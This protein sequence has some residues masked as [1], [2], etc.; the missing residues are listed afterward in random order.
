[1]TA[2]PGR[3]TAALSDRYRLEREL[4]QGGMATVY[5]AEDLKH[6]RKVAIKVLHPELSAVIGGDRFLTEI[7]VTANLQHPHILGLIDSGAVSLTTHD[8]RLSA[9]SRLS[10]DLL[11]YVMPYVS[12]ESLRHRLSRD[13]QL[14][15]ADALRLAK[16]VASALDYAHRQGVVHRDIKPE[17][18]LLQDGSALVADFGIALAVQQAGGSRMTQTGMSLGTPAYMSPEQAMGERDIG[19]RSDVY[20]LGAMTYEMLTGEPPFTGLNS[21]AIVAKVLTEQPPLLRPRRPL[22][23]SAVE[24]A[25]LTALQKLPADR[26]GSAKD[27]AD[28]LDDKGYAATVATSATRLP[29]PPRPPRLGLIAGIALISTAAG[30]AGWLAHR[31]PDAQVSRQ[32]VVL[33]QHPRGRLLAAGI[34]QL[35]TQSAIA[36]DGSSIVYTDSISGVYHLLRKRRS[37]R[38]AER[39]P[40]TEG[41]V[42]P[43]FSPDGKWIGYVT[44]DG[45]LRKV[46]VDGGGSITIAENLNTIQMAATWLDD[47]TIVYAGGE[48]SQLYQVSAEGGTPS[49][50]AADSGQR[51]NLPLVVSP[52]P[53]SRGILLTGCPGN[54]A[55][56]SN[57]YLLDFAADS[58]RLLVPDAA[59]AWISATGHLL[60]TDRAGGLYAAG[61]DPVKMVLTTPPRSIIEDV[62]PT[63]LALSQTGTALYTLGADNPRMSELVWVS[64]GGATEPV[65]TAWRGVFDYPALSPD[66]KALA[67][68]VR[69]G[70]T[71]IWIRRA[72]GTRQ[73]LTQEGTV[74]WR[75]SWSPDG[76]SIAF[77]SNKRGGGSQDAYDAWRMPVDGSAPPELLLR[78][79][80]GLWEAEL[81]RDGQWLVVRSDE[82]VGSA[83]IRGR[84]LTG[85]TTLLPLLVDLGVSMQ[86]ALSPDGRWLAWSANPTGQMEIYVA[87]FPSMKSTRLVSTG[88]GSEPRWAHSGKELFFKSGGKLMAVD[89]L[90]GEAFTFGTPHALFPLN[91]YLAARN[92]PQ[93]DV[94]PDDRRFLMIR[95]PG[96]SNEEVVYVENWFTEL[97]AKMAK[98]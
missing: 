32:R 30:L 62:A 78:H 28:A 17:N 26:Y 46:S 45:R 80:F 77:I 15:I 44:V 37:E 35:A 94:S 75:P 20:A 42:A 64:R 9:D 76:K 91:G 19:A 68:S 81:S 87:P 92:R 14:P 38:D 51:R 97:R 5:L 72:D 3:L 41:A 84:R 70:P 56:E 48:T 21:Q 67:V 13:K 53:G 66:G 29:R 43:F 34:S 63:T 82:A 23:P 50:M 90:P 4:G 10:T 83:N 54:C 8:S 61:F 98:K 69:D 6:G 59:G 25:V 12:G 1:M 88:G 85:D 40:G 52:I 96:A 95:V 73:K 79:T 86:A 57:V 60:Y 2:P 22:V 33:W 11:Y 7:R 18:I 93:Y 31:Q 89:V 24:A 39:I 49:P 36:P 65:D 71:H 58:S 47:G 27:F 55:I 74:N 16:E